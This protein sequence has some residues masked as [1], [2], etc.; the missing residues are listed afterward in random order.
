LALRGRFGTADISP[1]PGVRRPLPRF[2]PCVTLVLDPS[3]LFATSTSIGKCE[4][5]SFL[6]E[7]IELD[8]SEE[9]G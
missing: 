2:A 5:L 9:S 3:T 4:D 6:G 7:S 1:P 8:L